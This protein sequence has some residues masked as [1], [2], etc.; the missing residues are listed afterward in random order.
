[1]DVVVADAP[2]VRGWK[3]L[4]Q[5]PVGIVEA[6]RWLFLWVALVSLTLLLPGIVTTARGGLLLLGIGAALA[7]AVSWISGYRRRN[8]TILHDLVE[9]SGIL[10]LAVVCPDHRAIVLVVFGSLWF[11]SMYG[12]GGQAVARGV[13]YAVS[14]GSLLVVWRSFH[15]DAS[16][17]EF[18]SFLGIVPIMFLTIMIARK[19]GQS[20]GVRGKV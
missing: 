12:T 13:L 14:L 17:P 4:S 5:E 1:M 8:V 9:I 3:S 16:M 10:G 18:A 2:W 11:R 19:H 7:V 6:T 15:F 20:L